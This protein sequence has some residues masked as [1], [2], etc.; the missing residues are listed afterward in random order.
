MKF[1]LNQQLLKVCVSYK[2][3]NVTLHIDGVLYY[4]VVDPYKASYGVED[5]DF[6]I[7][8]LAQTTM[9][10]EIGQLTLDRTLA[11]RNLLNLNIVEQINHASNH[12]GIECL[13][14]EIRDIQPPELVVKSMHSQVSAER[15]KRAIVLESEGSK[16]SAINVAEGKKQ[17][18]I[19]NSEAERAEQINKAE[20]EARAVLLKAE[21]TAK[22]VE[23]ISKAIQEAGGSDAVSMI[24]AQKYIEA[25]S[26]LAKESNTLMLPTN[27]AEPTSMIGQ[28][29]SIYNKLQNSNTSY[30]KK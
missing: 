12:W 11:E 4:K 9:R 16:Q 5:A 17:A 23:Q 28:A 14:Y 6:S 13:R 1:H 15:Q 26:N 19:L 24:V 29:M 3:D 18:T 22:S 10:S 7:T 2:I 8:Q 27:V 20:G 25:F 30:S 21:A